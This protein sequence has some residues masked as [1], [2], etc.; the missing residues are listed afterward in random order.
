[1]TRGFK[2]NE[3]RKGSQSRRTAKGA[4]LEIRMTLR[5]VV[6]F[7]LRRHPTGV[8]RTELQ[9]ERSATRGHESHGD[10]GTKDERGQQYDGQHIESPSVMEPSSHA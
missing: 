3:V 7:M 1:L 2:C 8:G 6:M 9:Q 10:I 5:M 4:I